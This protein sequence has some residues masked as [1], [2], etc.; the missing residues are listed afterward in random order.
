VFTLM[1]R[2]A[3]NLVNCTFVSLSL[4]LSF[5]LS[6]Y[7]M[8]YIRKLYINFL[9]QYIRGKHAFNIAGM[10]VLNNQVISVQH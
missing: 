7:V 2:T 4:S 3:L 8:H 10:I 6:L 9:F 1:F 5:S